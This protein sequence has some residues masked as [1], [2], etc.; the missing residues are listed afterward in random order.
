MADAPAMAAGLRSF[1]DP[2]CRTAS[3]R[4]VSAPRRFVRHVTVALPGA[5]A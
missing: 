3:A 2:E 1:A 4:K 5:E